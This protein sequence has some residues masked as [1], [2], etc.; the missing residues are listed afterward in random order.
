MTEPEEKR[1]K[2]RDLNWLSFNQRV[3][4]EAGDDRNPVYERLKFLAIFSSNLDEYYRVRVSQL[5]QIK[6][7]NKDLRKKLALKPSK[8]VKEII[9]R[10][11][12]QQKQ[13]G[14]IFSE[15]IIPLLAS[16]GIH[17]VEHSQFTEDLKKQ[18]HQYYQAEIAAKI[19]TQSINFDTEREIFLENDTIYLLVS[20][21]DSNE[22][23]I[24]NI[25]V[26][27]NGR[28][29]H[30]SS[31]ENKQNKNYIVFVDDVVRTEIHQIF[32]DHEIEGIF[33]IKMSRDAELYLDDELE[34]VLA[35]KIYASLK[36]RQDGQPTR[37]LYDAE[38]GS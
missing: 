7:I 30:F 15:E 6:K 16:E 29:I 13:F 11:K 10:V 33:E 2:H 9:A 31:E 38:V 32:P 37:L 3:L 22:A 36:Q 19:E 27:G 20:F 4:Q 23:G 14:A 26:K 25:P 8:L 5:R 28:F 35:E 21:K 17:L 18:V 1:F 34:G 24:V 12:E